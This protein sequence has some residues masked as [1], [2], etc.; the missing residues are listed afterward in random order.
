M[1]IE[2]DALFRLSYFAT[3]ILS[4]FFDGLGFSTISDDNGHKV[5]ELD[6]LDTR[7]KSLVLIRKSDLRT[8]G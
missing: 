2:Y 3:N 7:R 6:G 8:K 5:Y 4:A 1:K